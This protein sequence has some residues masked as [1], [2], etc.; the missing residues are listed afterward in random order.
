MAKSKWNIYGKMRLSGSIELKTIELTLDHALEMAEIERRAVRPCMSHIFFCHF[1][2]L[3]PIS[4]HFLE[5]HH[6]L[7]SILDLSQ[8]Q[9]IIRLSF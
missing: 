4:L 1:D 3:K 7:P 2:I 8:C 6:L 5:F 9:D